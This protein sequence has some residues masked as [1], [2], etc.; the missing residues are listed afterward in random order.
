MEV[1]GEI[2]VGGEAY[3]V[4][5]LGDVRLVVDEEVGSVLE[6][7]AADEGVWRDAEVLL[8]LAVEVDSADAYVVAQ[9]LH[10]VF[11]VVDVRHDGLVDALEEFLFGTVHRDCAVVVADFC[12]SHLV[13]DSFTHTKHLVEGTAQELQVEW[14]WQEVVCLERD[15]LELGVLVVLAREDDDGD[16]VGVGVFFD[17]S[18]Q[19]VSVSVGHDEVGNDHV[20]TMG[21]EERPC[22]VAGMGGDDIEVLLQFACHI[23][24]KLLVVIDYHHRVAGVLLFIHFR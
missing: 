2:A 3:L 23:E 8:E 5:N 12:A 22:L 10:A 4:G 1:V 13:A 6:A 18:A 24:A 20:G 16:V 11:V 19:F 17:A 14:F 21:K 7:D 15:G 9:L